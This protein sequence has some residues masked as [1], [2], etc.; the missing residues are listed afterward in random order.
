M[1]DG[2]SQELMTRPGCLDATNREFF[3]IPENSVM[4][5]KMEPDT[6]AVSFLRQANEILNAHLQAALPKSR[7]RASTTRSTLSGK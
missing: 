1:A 2:K 7:Q 5:L 3:P 6:E 4:G